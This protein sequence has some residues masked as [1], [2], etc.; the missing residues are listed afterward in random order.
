MTFKVWLWLGLLVLGVSAMVPEDYRDTY[1]NQK[2]G[3]F[4]GDIINGTMNKIL[5]NISD[6][7]HLPPIAVVFK[8]NSLIS[9][10]L[11]VTNFKIDGLPNIVASVISYN[12]FNSKLNMTILVPDIDIGFGYWADIGIGELIPLYGA[13][14]N[15]IYSK[16]I[17][18]NVNGCAKLVSGGLTFSDIRVIL[19]FGEM[20]F[21][22]NGLLNN[23][24]LSALVSSI[25]TDNVQ[26]FVNNDQELITDLISPIVEIVMNQLF[27][28][29]SDFIVYPKYI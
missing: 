9:G 1:Q 26:N 15:N 28:P 21:N 24:E 7:V 13:G 25:L 23:S 2:Y 4:I 8:N 20:T 5:R 17:T 6:S 16:L 27:K 12:I 18:I 19:H 10:G 3:D 29:K 11:N 14:R 22:L